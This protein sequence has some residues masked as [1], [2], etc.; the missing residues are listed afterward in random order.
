MDIADQIY[1]PAVPPLAA[2]PLLRA[3]QWRRHCLPKDMDK[4]DQSLAALAKWWPD[5]TTPIK[6]VFFTKLDPCWAVFAD[7]KGQPDISARAEAEM[8]L[9]YMIL[10]LFHRAERDLHP[11]RPDI[12]HE[13]VDFGK[14]MFRETLHREITDLDHDLAAPF[15]ACLLALADDPDA[16]WDA[17]RAAFAALPDPA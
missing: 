8:A 2:I 6:D 9:M 11:E 3:A 12:G 5:A 17:H 16:G 4:I 14:S 15:K 10:F 7:L 1:D 13:F